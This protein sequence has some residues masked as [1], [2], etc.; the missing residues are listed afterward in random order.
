MVPYTLISAYTAGLSRFDLH[1]AVLSMF[2]SKVL[3]PIICSHLQTTLCSAPH[4]CP[5]CFRLLCRAPPSAPLLPSSRL[6][7]R[8]CPHQFGPHTAVPSCRSSL[9]SL[10]ATRSPV[11][12]FTIPRPILFL[13]Y[14]VLLS[15][16]VF[17]R[18]DDAFTYSS[19]AHCRA[20]TAD[21]KWVHERSLK[22]C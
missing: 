19:A 4:C 18:P 5:P 21:T 22:V 6:C 3:L 16:H 13:F 17:F 10:S 2:F 20:R 8:S 1:T 12:L 7:I 9:L 11:Y 14:S 15:H